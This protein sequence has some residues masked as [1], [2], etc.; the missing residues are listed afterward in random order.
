MNLE[1][2]FE[3]S[4]LSSNRTLYEI[5][6][7]HINRTIEEHLR[8][9]FSHYHVVAFNETTGHVIRK[10]T[11][12]GYADWSCWSQGQAW[13]I[14]GLTIAYRFTRSD[15]ILKAAEGVTNYLIDRSPSDAI[16]FWDFDVPHDQNHRYIPRDSSSASIAASGINELFGFTGNPKYLNAFNKIMENLFSE[17]YRADSKLEYRIPALL[18]NGTADYKRGDYDRAL[19]F[20]DYY[21]VKS[22]AHYL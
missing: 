18:V 10:F 14:A 9:D 2:L 3:A 21:F 7:S 13:L 19:I 22:L 12:T 17:K 1:L 6:V 15:Y 16:P 20:G 5:A 11:A 8:P 4:E